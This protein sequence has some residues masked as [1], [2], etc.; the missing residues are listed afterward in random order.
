MATAQNAPV[1][2]CRQALLSIGEASE[3]YNVHPN[4][5]R[6]YCDVGQLPVLTLPSGHRRLRP[7]DVE[8]FLGVVEPNNSAPQIKVALLARV[9]SYG[10][11]KGFSNETGKTKDGVGEESD[12][13]RQV[14]R[15]RQYAGEKYGV[16]GELFSDIGSG[17]NFERPNFVRLVDAVL[18][19]RL[20]GGVILCTYKDRL[21]RFGHGLFQRI[22]EYGQVE[23][24]AI[25]ADPEKSNETELV[26]D[27]LA[28]TTIFSAKLHGK[29]AAKALAV[30]IDDETIQEAK[31]I[32]DKGHSL[33]EVAKQ[34]FERGYRCRKGKPIS[35]YILKRVLVLNGR[36]INPGDNS[37]ASSEPNSSA[38][39]QE[40]LDERVIELPGT[41]TRKKTL[42]Q[43]Y[44]NWAKR[45]GVEPL[46]GRAMGK[47]LVQKYRRK[48]DRKGCMAYVDITLKGYH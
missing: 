38:Q 41:V 19:G 34:L 30:E 27:M 18:A 43:D 23:V 42:Y 39:I 36:F 28:L 33:R 8:K 44:A 24:V 31:D 47:I 2:P 6:R 25:E 12:L 10:Q 22:C 1:R 46:T 21:M 40:W 20:K 3:L 29:R 13:A 37:L 48:L 9:S 16:E 14:E 45:K 5:L 35:S 7:E 17:L 26:E 32:Y 11:G 15:L 4:T